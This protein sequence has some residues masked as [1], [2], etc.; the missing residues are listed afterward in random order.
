M[1]IKEV[2]EKYKHMDKA[3]CDTY[4]FNTLIHHI[5][6]DLWE[7]IRAANVPAKSAEYRRPI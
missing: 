2:Y 5:A 7:A 3:L 1:N 6:K 4:T